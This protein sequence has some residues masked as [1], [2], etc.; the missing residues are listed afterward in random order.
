[1]KSSPIVPDLPSDSALA[2]RAALPIGP[3][4]AAP[5]RRPTEHTLRLVGDADRP[6][7]PVAPDPDAED[8]LDKRLL[9]RARSGDQDALAQ[10]LQRHEGRVYSLCVRIVRDPDQ[11]A[12]L[13][14]DTLVRL[15]QR[16]DRFSGRSRFSTWVYRVTVNVC[17]TELRRSGR[18]AKLRRRLAASET[19]APAPEPDAGES[20]QRDERLARLYAAMDTLPVQQRAILILRDVQGLDYRRVGEVLGLAAGTVK[21]R[22]F[23]AREA[24]R[25]AIEELEAEPP[26]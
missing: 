12:D 6:D 22:L 26:T 20:V 18:R 2:L 23:R 10:L 8:R 21:S 14:Q 9:G 15:I 17:L 4:P 13:A 3:R 7:Q 11:A 24:L 25:R 5:P 16:L 1:M 19:S